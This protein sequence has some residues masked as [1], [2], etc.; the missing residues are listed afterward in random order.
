MATCACYAYSP[1][2]R[3]KMFLQLWLRRYVLM[4]STQRRRTPI[5]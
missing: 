4:R 3:V 1:Q 2:S 5:Y